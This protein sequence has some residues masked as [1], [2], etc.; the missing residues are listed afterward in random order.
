MMI[1]IIFIMTVACD[2]M[3]FCSSGFLTKQKWHVLKP[4]PRCHLRHYYDFQQHAVLCTLHASWHVVSQQNHVA[5]S[6]YHLTPRVRSVLWWELWNSTSKWLGWSLLDSH[7]PSFCHLSYVEN[8][9]KTP[10][11]L[12]FSCVWTSRRSGWDSSPT[13]QHWGML[14]HLS[15]LPRDSPWS[16]T[17]NRFKKGNLAW[18]KLKCC[19]LLPLFCFKSNIIR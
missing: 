3:N 15:D 7:F 19:E 10:C 8:R 17:S 6:S 18:Q 2:S 1:M 12:S 9:F 11:F 13:A 16:S 5:A 4:N 14:Q